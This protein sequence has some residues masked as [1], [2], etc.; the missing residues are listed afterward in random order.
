MLTD[1]GFTRLDV[2]ACC[3]CVIFQAVGCVLACACI[4]HPRPNNSA[5]RHCG[6]CGSSWT[7]CRA[8]SPAAVTALASNTPTSTQESVSILTIEPMI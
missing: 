5:H 4:N 8:P 2:C 1:Q 3:Q 7:A 6:S